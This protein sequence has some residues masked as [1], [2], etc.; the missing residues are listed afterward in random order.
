MKAK[1]TILLVTSLLVCTQ[2]AQPIFF[3]VT[4]IHFKKPDSE[5]QSFIVPI[6][7]ESLLVEARRLVELAAQNW[8]TPPAPASIVLATVV[9]GRDAVNRNYLLTELP[10][11]SWHVSRVV[12]FSE[13]CTCDELQ[14][15]TEI[16]IVY[17]I[18]SSTNTYNIAMGGYTITKELGTTPL[19]L[20]ISKGKETVNVYWSSP[21]D[22]YKFTLQ[23]A[24]IA[25]NGQTD[26]LEV[27]GAL[28][29]MKTNH[30]SV[31]I[32]QGGALYRVLAVTDEGTFKQSH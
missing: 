18:Y 11:W 13:L 28:W 6:T 10:E 30:W 20:N 29:P 25:P 23:T 22:G 26:W 1:T 2:G 32:S 16:E 9:P 24:A 19:E 7:D 8:P 4:P 15:P 27:D 17:A 5:K 21:G 31:P 14:K 3:L 12:G